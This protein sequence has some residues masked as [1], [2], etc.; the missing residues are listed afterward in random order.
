MRFNYYLFDITLIMINPD[1]HNMKGINNVFRFVRL[2]FL[3]FLNYK[4][5]YITIIMKK[6][7]HYLYY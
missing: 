1:H 2:L 6:L 5:I 4:F 7:L 3:F